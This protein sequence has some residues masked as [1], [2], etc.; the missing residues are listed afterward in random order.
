MYCYSQAICFP[1]VTFYLNKPP[2]FSFRIKSMV[3]GYM[4]SKELWFGAFNQYLLKEYE[5]YKL[6]HR[7]EK[8]TDSYF[9]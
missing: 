8:G 1:Q 9:P 2:W 3:T 4:E 6:V 7:I 5:E